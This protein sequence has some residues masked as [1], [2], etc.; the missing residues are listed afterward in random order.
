V[1]HFLIASAKVDVF[2]I[3]GKL[4]G[5]N[6]KNIFF[7]TYKILIISDLLVWVIIGKIIWK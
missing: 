1:H 7:L 3:T 2:V 6:F 4:F 5:K